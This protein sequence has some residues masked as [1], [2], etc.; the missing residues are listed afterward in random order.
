M[1]SFSLETT[2]LKSFCNF[3]NTLFSSAK[4]NCQCWIIYVQVVCQCV[5]LISIWNFHKILVD[6]FHIHFFFF[7]FF[8]FFF[9][10]LFCFYISFFF[11]LICFFIHFLFISIT[12][13]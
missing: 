3:V 9:L 2:C 7:Y 6:I 4:Y 8:F 5:K 11:F 12:L 13:Y 10:L 1:N